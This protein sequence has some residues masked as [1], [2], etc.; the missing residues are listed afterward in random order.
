MRFKYILL[1]L[2]GTVTDSAEGVINSVTYALRKLDY[3]VEQLG[4]MM[5]FIGPPLKQSFKEFCCFDEDTIQ[6]GVE[7][8][9]EYYSVTGITQLRLYGGIEHL[10]QTLKS[11]GKKVVLAT[12][13]P[14]IYAKR[15]L[16]NCG[17]TE[18]FDLIAGSTLD[19]SRNTKAEVL[20]YILDTIKLCS[21]D[22]CLM[23]GDRKHDIIGAHSLGLK[24]AA[25]LYGY[26]NRAEFEQYGADYIVDSV[27]ELEEFLVKA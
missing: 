27:E 8:Y 6:K 7:Y 13:K 25:V 23:V 21:L 10:L 17:I 18:Y 16:E 19:A 14:E 5:K 11:H 1:D 26:G 22:D 24:C 2:D 15:I 9:R 4:S 3:P 12:S 20:T